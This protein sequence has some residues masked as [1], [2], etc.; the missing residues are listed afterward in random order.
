MVSK[1][2][3]FY[4]IASEGEIR[5]KDI[6]EAMNKPESEYKAIFNHVMSL[7]K[8]GYVRRNRTVKVVLDSESKK[9][10]GLISFCMKNRINY[11][12]MLKKTMVGFILKAARKEFFTNKD[13]GIHPQ[14]FSLYVSALSKYGL[15][16]VM[17]KKPLK[18]KLLRHHFLTELAGFFGKKIEFYTDVKR[19]LIPEI[20][21]ELR[22]YRRNLRIEYTAVEDK[23]RNKE[24][25]YIY[26][27]LNLEGNPLTLP[28]TQ[29]LIL[30][31]IVPE[32]RK[33]EHIQET[34]NYRK[35]V[36]LMMGNAKKKVKLD[37][38]LIL[39]YHKIAMSH[40]FGA[41]N[42]RKHNVRIKFNPDFK[43]CDWNLVPLKL[44]ELLEKYREFESRKGYTADIIRF[45]SFF[46]NEFQRIHP[47]TDGNS[48][49]S[50]LLM[51]HI[52]RSHGIPVLDLPLGYFD[53]YL[54]LTKR[55]T[56]RDDES[57]NY[58]VE[59]IILMNLKGINRT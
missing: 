32:K 7:E 55:S 42:I 30:E 53:M 3:V 46:H 6:A 18:C 49:I 21:K 37:L 56:K 33:L 10:F 15:L 4:V 58:L 26:S 38:G 34:T 36:D 22:K 24:A 35:A 50:R 43:T 59:E 2:D 25:D 41:G 45:A 5:P 8:E 40:I 47:F 39:E 29:K 27:S 31:N 44:G 1:Y 9:L 19:S 57:F 23:E 28:E 13:V 51:L 11:N 20:E 52:F 17:S 48:R 12:L 16:L 14:T 54:N